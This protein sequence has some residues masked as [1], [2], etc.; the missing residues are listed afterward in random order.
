MKVAISGA[1]LKSCNSKRNVS[2]IAPISAVPVQASAAAATHT[3]VT[4]NW[5]R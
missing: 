5:F 2:V 4:K 1:T 3:K